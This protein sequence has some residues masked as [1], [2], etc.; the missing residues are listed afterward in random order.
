M[1]EQLAKTV[2]PNAPEAWAGIWAA[3]RTRDWRM[4]AMLNVYNRIATLMP[5]A[6]HVVDLGGGVGDLAVLLKSETRSVEVWEHNTPAIEECVLRGVPAR[7]VDLNSREYPSIDVQGDK[8]VVFVGTEMLEHLEDGTMDYLLSTAGHVGKAFFSVPNW[9][10]PPEVEPQHKRMFSAISFKRELERYFKNVRVECIDRAPVG[11]QQTIHHYYLLGICGFP[12]TCSLSVTFPARNEA[13]DIERTLASFRG[14]A[15]EMVIGIDPRST[16]ET[17]EIARRYAEQVF[18]LDDPKGRGEEKA[19]EVHFADIRN[20]CIEHCSSEWIF[21]TEAHERLGKGLDT[22]LNLDRL[23]KGTK[24]VFVFRTGQGQRWGFPWLIK[25]DPEIRYKRTTHN[26]VDYPE[27]TPAVRMSSIV[28]I[29]E[30]SKDNAEARK[31]QRKVQNRKA[32]FEDWLANDNEQSLYYFASELRDFSSD[33]A[34]ERLEQ[35]LNRPSKM[36]AMRYQARL[37]LAKEYMRRGE[38][39]EARRVLLGCAGEDWSRGEHW[40][41][42]GDLAFDAGQLE[43]A[44]QWYRY[45]GTM[46]G[47]PP[48]TI[49]WIDIDDYGHLGAQRLAMCYAALNRGPEALHWAKKALEMLPEEA[50]AAAREECERNIAHLE[51][52]LEEGEES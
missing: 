2:D 23:P 46:S 6:A 37:V 50:P 13:A 7:L 21:M 4:H 34:V 9:V 48:W 42:L 52:A 12:K 31:V 36:G 19:A 25:N 20:Q 24:L 17:E 22:L 44:L 43:E 49:W 45:I 15:D 16:D 41:W 30:R 26:V 35:L 3:Q 1:Q 39:G 32:L 47:E 5:K 51:K 8:P 18:I 33:K 29:H 40:L 28:T 27:G 38:M 14:A 11:E 10:L